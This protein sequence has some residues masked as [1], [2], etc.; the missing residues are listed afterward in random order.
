MPIFLNSRRV[1]TADHQRL[2]SFLKS[3]MQKDKAA[4]EENGPQCGPYKKCILSYMRFI[5]A[6]KPAG[7]GRGIRID[8]ASDETK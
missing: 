2:S 6:K 1:R 5:V 3:E 8:S 7:E 4:V